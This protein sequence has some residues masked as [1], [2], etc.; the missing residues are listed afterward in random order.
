MPPPAIRMSKGCEVMAWFG[1]FLGLDDVLL[2]S[3]IFR[4]MASGDC[5]TGAYIAA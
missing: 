4:M 2:T 3:L 1:L 5:S